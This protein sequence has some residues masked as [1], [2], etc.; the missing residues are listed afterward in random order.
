MSKRGYYYD[1]DD[2][3]VTAD[4]DDYVE[5]QRKIT[6][7]YPDLSEFMNPRPQTSTSRVSPAIP[8]DIVS[9]NEDR[10]E[11]LSSIRQHNKADMKEI[12]REVDEVDDVDMYDIPGPSNR[13]EPYTLEQKLQLRRMERMRKGIDAQQKLID[14][15]IAQ[16]RKDKITSSSP[17]SPP[18]TPQQREQMKRFEQRLSQR[19]NERTMTPEQLRQMGRIE[20]RIEQ[21]RIEHTPPSSSRSVPLT[22]TQQHQLDRI[23]KKRK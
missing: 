19:R 6:R 8:A 7:L 13:S 4:E 5:P 11:I 9:P 10:K 20:Q 1:S 2:D 18:M 23:Q 14:Q 22:I 12:K 15:R 17:R 3:Y 16:R 21:R